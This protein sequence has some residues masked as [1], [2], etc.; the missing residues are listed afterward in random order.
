MLKHTLL[1]A[2][3]AT[4]AAIGLA[5]W[6]KT[7]LATEEAKYTVWIQDGDFEV[8]DYASSVQAEVVVQGQREEAG[9]KAFNTLFQYISGAN[10]SRQK[11]A[12]T[13]PVGQSETIAMTAPV[14]L[15][16]SDQGWV[17]SFMLP[18]S[19]GPDTAPEPTDPRVTLRTL[20]ARRVAS[21]RYAGGDDQA[22]YQRKLD[23]L[24]A[25]IRQRGLESTGELVWARYN[26][27]FMPPFWRRNEILLTLKFTADPD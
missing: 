22:T 25:W 11:I 4:T 8:R 9:N 3:I 15:S 1:T 10:R 17:V 6:A 23:A 24:Q 16:P 20:P 12:M 19:L 21:V 26:P 5:F 2:L 27:P 7:A 14:G 18:A 13:A